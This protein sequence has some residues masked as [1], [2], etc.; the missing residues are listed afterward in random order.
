MNPIKERKRLKNSSLVKSIA[1]FVL[2]T[3][4]IGV[5]PAVVQAD[6][7]AKMVTLPTSDASKREVVYARLSATGE[8]DSVYV[9]NHFSPSKKSSLTDYGDYEEV[10]QLTGSAPPVLSGTTVS[11]AE[12][13]GPY[14]YQ[15]NL[16]S[17][18]LPWL[19]D[20]TWK[21]DGEVR[22][23][24]TLSGVSGELEFE[25]SVKSNEKIDADFF[26]QYAL[27][28]S[29]PIDPERSKIVAAS[30]GFMVSYAGTEQQMTYMALPSME[31]TFKVILD[32]SDFAMAQMTIAGIPLSLD[33]D[34]DTIGDEF[35]EMLAPLEELESGI[36]DF[37]DGAAQLRKG[38]EELLSAYNQVRDGSGQLVSGGDQLT[39]GVDQLKKGVKDYTTGVD[40]YVQ[41]VGQLSKGYQA[42]DQGVRTM[43]QGTKQLKAEG[44]Q[45]IKGS[46]DILAG[47]NQIVDQLS[48][49]DFDGVQL[50]N[51]DQDTLAELDALVE[52][53]EQVRD[54]LALL[55]AASGP[56]AAGLGQTQ[57]QLAG[58]KQQA[59]QFVIPENNVD[60]MTAAEWEYYITTTLG[61]TAS[62]N[63]QQDQL[64]Y[65]QL[66]GMSKLASGYKP[67][68]VMLRGTIDGLLNQQQGIPALANGASEISGG[69]QQLSGQ[70]GELHDGIVELVEQVKGLAA[71]SGQF[72][73]LR[74][75]FPLL[76]GGLKNLR[77]GYAGVYGADGKPVVGPDGK[78]MIGFHNGL[79][80]YIE[81]GV[82]GLLKG[83]E[84]VGGKPGLLS[85]SSEIKN[86]LAALAKNGNKLSSGGAELLKGITKTGQGIADYVGGISSFDE[87]LDRYR[88]DGLIPYYD[89]LV[90]FEEGAETLKN[91]TSDLPQKFEDAIREMMEEYEGSFD[92]QSFV[93]DKNKDVASVQFVFMTEE[94]PPKAK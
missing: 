33:V 51:I 50:P 57:A 81:Q 93:S 17:R 53:S 92:I 18:E 10:I 20:M 37:A 16:K 22:E 89:G 75:Q 6:R 66:A 49:V 32:V 84:G 76:V 43:Y 77:D 65:N 24:S 23:P 87:G 63:P 79:K 40:R 39:G 9:V 69:L 36:A 80:A 61:F 91:E 82:G 26:N 60:S 83:Y 11:I 42:F 52:G 27:Q 86:G 45:L 15:G 78:P 7:E 56:L 55:A 8:V 70:Y 13:E 31:T 72:A 47:L 94:I 28:I 5:I 2:L 54:N 73:Q 4:V 46:A 85:G 12:A 44:A 14:Y 3:L 62:G 25:M 74:D 58:L 64:L 41:G 48:A 59:D 34:L 35:D 21:L 90:T 88:A 19:F 30:E 1:I 71:L 68:V 67:A 38:Y 29:I